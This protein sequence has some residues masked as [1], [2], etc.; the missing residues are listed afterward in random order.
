[1]EK[2]LAVEA[3]SDTRIRTI[4]VQG[5]E[6]AATKIASLASN[7]TFSAGVRSAQIRLTMEVVRDVHNS[8]FKQALPVI[9]KGQNDAADTAVDAFGATDLRYLRAALRTTGAVDSFVDGQR[10]QA[11]LQ[12][13]HAVNS[14][15]RSDVPLSSRVYRTRSLANGWVKRIVVS[16]I[17]RG[18]SAV[19]IGKAVRSHISPGVAGGTHY[20]A[21]RLGRTEIN[22]AFH[23][24]TI[25]LAKN[26]PWVEEMRWNLSKVHVADD[27]DKC[28]TY[29]AIGLFS[30]G[31]TPTKPHPQ[32]R[33]FCTPE[34]MDFDSFATNLK[35]GYYRDWTSRNAA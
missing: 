23:A 20:A 32:C 31:Q 11:E 33:C 6:D 4:L 22:N 34:L 24:T 13:A 21:L 3:K 10:K 16:S 12:V 15:T 5:A 19:D 9:K 35:A 17:M 7:S 14:I 27:G 18:D 29:A 30:V 8:I 1:M 2:Y 28:E 25:D 26:R